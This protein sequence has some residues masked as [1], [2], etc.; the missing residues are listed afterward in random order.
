MVELGEDK[1]LIEEFRLKLNNI[2]QNLYSA[3]LLKNGYEKYVADKIGAKLDKQQHYDCIWKDRLFLELKKGK[4]HVWL[5]LCRYVENLEKLNNNF[6]MFLFYNKDKGK[7]TNIFVVN[8]KRLIEYLNLS[9]WKVM[10]V[11]LKSK[12][13]HESMN[14]QVRLTK[15]DLAGLREFEIS[16]AVV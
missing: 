14:A 15:K 6:T 3:E 5:D 8:T 10:L 16:N 4:N 1:K 13:P 9:R 12:S 7:M 2:F 11:E